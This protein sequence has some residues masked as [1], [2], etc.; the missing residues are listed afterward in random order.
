MIHLHTDLLGEGTG[1]E[2]G[3]SIHRGQ[4][5][6]GILWLVVHQTL[7]HHQHAIAD[8]LN[9]VTA[10]FQGRG[11]ILEESVLT[12]VEALSLG[13][14]GERVERAVQGIGLTGGHTLSAQP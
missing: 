13:G 6:P 3:V 10:S 7:I 4:E 1:Y 2:E 9:I 12:L 14:H 11:D 5:I 8:F